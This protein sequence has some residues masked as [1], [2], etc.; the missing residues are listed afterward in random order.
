M[1]ILIYSLIRSRVESFIIHHTFILTVPHHSSSI[2]SK[3]ESTM[4][5]AVGNVFI[6]MAGGLLGPSSKR[7]K[8][9]YVARPMPIMPNRVARGSSSSLE[10]QQGP[11]QL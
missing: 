6:A 10:Q 8:S 7:R 9:L 11:G 3:F 5:C 1:H 2:S 4:S